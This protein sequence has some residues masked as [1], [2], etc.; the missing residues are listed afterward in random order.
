MNCLSPIWD[1]CTAWTGL[2]DINNEGTYVWDHSN[3][4]LTFS[5]WMD[6]EPSVGYPN[7]AQNRDCMDILRGGVW[8]DRP[9]SYLNWFICEKS[10]WQW[11]TNISNIIVFNEN[12]ILC[13]SHIELNSIIFYVTNLSI[14]LNDLSYI[15]LGR[16]PFYVSMI[17]W[18]FWSNE[19]KRKWTL[20]SVKN[21]LL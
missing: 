21:F 10:L 13:F 5:N 9:C 16:F 3:A 20:E 14:E 15:S 17:Q 11:Y 2:N 1:D 18:M 19:S 7:H 8:N 4:P 12:H 6:G